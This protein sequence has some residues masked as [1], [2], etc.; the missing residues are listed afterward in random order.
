MHASFYVFM[1]NLY[2]RKQRTSKLEHVIFT[3]LEEFVR[4]RLQKPLTQIASLSIPVKVMAFSYMVAVETEFCLTLQIPIELL[5]TRLRFS[6]C[7]SL[8]LGN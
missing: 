7:S 8:K 5:F 2:Q 4:K 6:S 1:R 3:K